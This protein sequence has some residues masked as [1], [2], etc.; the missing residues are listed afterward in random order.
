MTPP[1]ARLAH[2]RVLE[3]C[4]CGLHEGAHSV[5]SEHPAGQPLHPWLLETGV[6]WPHTHSSSL[7][8]DSLSTASERQSLPSIWLTSPLPFSPTAYEIPH[9]TACFCTWRMEHWHWGCRE[10]NTI[11]VVLRIRKSKELSTFSVWP[12]TRYLTSA[13]LHVLTHNVG[14]EWWLRKLEM[15]YKRFWYIVGV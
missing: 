5:T 9:W 15:M 2:S 14:L 1:R 12:Q 8:G 10:N 6:P 3:R 11:E 4:S 13:C 7:V